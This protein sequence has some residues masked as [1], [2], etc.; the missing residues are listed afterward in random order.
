MRVFRIPIFVWPGKPKAVH[1]DMDK[2]AKMRRVMWLSVEASAIEAQFKHINDRI[3]V[4]RKNGR[5][6]VY[7]PRDIPENQRRAIRAHWSNLIQAA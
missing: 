3:K 5:I 1:Q 2:V 7:A 4:V 6:E